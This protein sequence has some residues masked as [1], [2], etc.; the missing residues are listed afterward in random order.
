MPEPAAT[1]RDATIELLP[2]DGDAGLFAALT[3]P[4]VIAELLAILVVAALSLTVA[5]LLRARFRRVGLA[6]RS[7]SAFMRGSASTE[8]RWPGSIVTPAPPRCASSSSRDTA[9]ATSV[10]SACRSAI[11]STS[12]VAGLSRLATILPMRSRLDA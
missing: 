8:T 5:H 9:A 11:T 2:A 6:A 12:P 7:I 4:E 1:P 10:A 3:R